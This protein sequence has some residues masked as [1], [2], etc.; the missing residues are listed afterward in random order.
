MAKWGFYEGIKKQ[1]TKKEELKRKWSYSRGR[2]R[3]NL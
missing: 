2:E 3:E 1:K